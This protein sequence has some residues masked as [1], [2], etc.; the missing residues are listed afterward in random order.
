MVASSDRAE[1]RRRAQGDLRLF[2]ELA[3]AEGELEI[4]RGADPHLEMGALYELSLEQ[5][6]PPVLLFE[7]MT[8]CDPAHR[9]I[10][11]VRSARLFQ[12]GQGIERVQQYRRARQQKLEPIPPRLVNTG[13]VLENVRRGAE[14]DVTRFPAPKWHAGDGGNYIGTECLIVTKDP[15]S[16]WVNLGTYRVQVQDTKTLSVSI[17][18]GKDGDRI[19]RKYWERGLACPMAISVGQA[20]ILGEVAASTYGHHISEYAIAGGRIGRPLD[21]VQGEVTGLPI[22]ADAELVFEGFMPPP[23]EE[24]RDE[25]PFGEW[26]GYYG[27]NIR[28]QPVFRVEALYHRDNPIVVAQPPAKPTKPGTWYGT[29]GTALL[30]AANLWDELEAAGVPGIKGVWKLPGGGPRLINVVA[31]EQLHAGHAKMAGLVATGCGGAAFFGRITII[32][33]DDIDITD[34]AEVMWAVATRWDPKSQT[35]IIEGCWSG[36]IDPLLPPDKRESGDVTNSRIIIYAVRPFAWQ[37]QFPK[38]N[39]VDRAY[40]DEVRSKWAGKLKFLVDLAK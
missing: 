23:E 5:E 24:A 4:V 11:N 37:D 9:V 16:D 30:R 34:P 3:R 7:E 17:E 36:Y 31:I 28:P 33:D 20:P 15:D 29:A 39:M 19:R 10:A 12:E 38:V 2:L 6:D 26:P 21:L 22:P 14:I 13:P 35:D 40:A 32:V 18:P 27:S 1:L 25:G 8:G